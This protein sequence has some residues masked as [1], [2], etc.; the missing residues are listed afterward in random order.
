LKPPPLKCRS[1]SGKREENPLPKKTEKE[2]KKIFFVRRG[3]KTEPEE[4]N[5][6][7]PP[8]SPHFQPGALRQSCASPNTVAVEA[9]KASPIQRAAGPGSED[10]ERVGEIDAQS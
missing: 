9:G 7:K 3:K 6:F 4:D 1:H 8:Q 2:E 5:N 10:S